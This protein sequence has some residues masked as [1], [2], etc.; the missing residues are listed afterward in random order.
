MNFE[1]IMR[2]PLR[3]ILVIQGQMN[4]IFLSEISSGIRYAHNFL[5]TIAY[6]DTRKFFTLGKSS[7]L[8]GFKL[9]GFLVGI[10][11]PS[12]RKLFA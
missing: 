5:K 3:V 11:V 10:Q 6:S 2:T 9:P 12:Q 7:C 4:T 1:G 8:Q